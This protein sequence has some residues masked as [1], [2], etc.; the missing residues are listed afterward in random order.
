VPAA[1]SRYRNAGLITVRGGQPGK[2]QVFFGG[3]VAP[4]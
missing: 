1:G 4:G 2:T 3:Q